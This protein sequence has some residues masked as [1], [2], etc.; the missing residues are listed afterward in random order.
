MKEEKLGVEGAG[1]AEV[2][3]VFGVD[4]V[5]EVDK[6]LEEMYC[7]MKQVQVFCRILKYYFIIS[8]L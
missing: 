8:L 2:A 4:E 5:D 1:V 7:L 6:V 3:K